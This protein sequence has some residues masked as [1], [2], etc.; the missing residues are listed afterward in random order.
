MSLFDNHSIRHSWFIS[1]NA[2]LL[3]LVS[4]IIFSIVVYYWTGHTIEQKKQLVFETETEKIVKTIEQRLQD[5]ESALH[6]FQG[7]YATTH[8]EQQ[9]AEAF[10]VFISVMDLEKRYPGIKS[11]E[12]C[13][14]VP[15][16]QKDFFEKETD[17]R[18]YPHTTSQNYFPI[19]YLYPFEKNKVGFDIGTDRNNRQILELAIQRDNFV[20]GPPLD[21]Q[22]KLNKTTSKGI[23]FAGSV[24]F[25]QAAP[26]TY[27][28]SETSHIQ[29]QK[30]GLK[31]I[32][33][34]ML[35]IKNIVDTILK[36]KDISKLHVSLFDIG[37]F[38]KR[39][40]NIQPASL[41]TKNL[42][43]SNYTTPNVIASIQ[44]DLVNDASN[45]LV[46]SV[47]IGLREWQVICH[48]P[49]E[50]YSE[51]YN[52]NIIPLLIFSGGITISFFL[53]LVVRLLAKE[54]IVAMQLAG[55]MTNELIENETQLR[56][57][58]NALP[59]LAFRFDL[60]TTL[61]R[62]YFL[63]TTS[64][65]NDKY[66]LKF[67]FKP[68]QIIGQTIDAIFIEN[69]SNI[70]KIYAKN[71][72]TDSSQ[73]TLFELKVKT[74]HAIE[75]I[76]DLHLAYIND[77]NDDIVCIM[78]DM[79][80]RRAEQNRLFQSEQMLRT[81]L[82]AIPQRV[83]WKDTESHFLG[84]NQLF[85][86]D[87]GLSHPDDLIGKT[88]YEMPWAEQAE[89]YRHI[90]RKVLKTN[91]P[92]LNFEEQ[93]TRD[94]GTLV[95]V[96]TNK[97]PLF[98]HSNEVI[99]IIGTYDD[100]TEQKLLHDSLRESETRTRAIID[101][102]ADAIIVINQWELIELFNPAAERIFGY[103]QMEALGKNIALLMP[104]NVAPIHHQF[105]ER[106]LKTGQKNVIN[107]ARELNAK[108]KNGEIFP[109]EISVTAIE[110]V[111]RRLFIGIIRDISLR[112]AS[113]NE[114][115]RLQRNTENILNALG[116]GVIGVN[117][118]DDIMFINPAAKRMLGW[119]EAELI[120]RNRHLLINHSHRDNTEYHFKDSAIFMTLSH[121]STCRISDE[122]FW[123]KNNHYF[124]VE[125]ITTPIIEQETV[126]GAVIVFQDITERKRSIDALIASENKF[127]TLFEQSQDAILILNE[128]TIVDC[129]LAAIKMLNATASSLVL[130]RSVLDFSPEIQPDEGLPSSFIAKNVMK[131]M[132]LMGSLRFEWWHKRLD[133]SIFPVEVSMTMIP[134]NGKQMYHTVWRDLTEHKKAQAEI[135]RHRDHLQELV[136]E[137]TIDLIQAKELA[138]EGNR[139]KSEFLA[140]MSH[141][142][143][144]PMHAIMSFSEFG[145]EDITDYKSN[146][147]VNT[148]TVT[149]EMR[150]LED[151]FRKIYASGK[152]LLSLLND[153]LDLSKLDAGK[154]IFDMHDHH[155]HTIIQ[156]TTSELESL[157]RKHELTLIIEAPTQAPPVVHC[158]ATKIAHVLR[159]LLSNAI[160]FTPAGKLI[161]IA[162]EVYEHYPLRQEITTCLA[163]HVKDQGIGVPEDELKLIFDKFVQSSKT[164]TGSGGTG[165]G[166]AICKQI[167]EAHQGDIFAQNNPDGGACLTFL[168]PI[169]HTIS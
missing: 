95:W 63:P 141:E 44:E 115:K 106:Y 169:K 128:L 146:P 100:I 58:L 18:I 74:T 154:M 151:Y 54:R 1:N 42:I 28:A 40:T 23:L 11:L 113:E 122:I 67:P 118:Q 101:T 145:L 64:S 99:G 112:K 29:V 166:L 56:I 76:Y 55:N 25:R 3:I 105:V 85:A 53:F 82:N 124:P 36:E 152:R 135:L 159:N 20:M 10:Q 131:Q 47:V 116:E 15:E 88:D 4:S 45:V 17:I 71:L 119:P 157:L 165:L 68:E 70:I 104:I 35:D 87:A 27:E 140:N 13:R 83:F 136:Q 137:Q 161:K 125:Y 129:N 37:K 14:F 153:L 108:R 59:D 73:N 26:L 75:R 127:R 117:L 133:G 132:N 111:D 50:V 5:Y 81:I 84:C 98:N 16:Y 8:Q 155:I 138:E 167:I 158:D 41:T 39:T 65:F 134:L 142:L 61:I 19:E 31:G 91:Q 30:K 160:K 139:A 123:D 149:S 130:Q 79:T 148:D 89:F 69:I 103:S 102:A 32:I 24:F 38:E 93:Q 156:N 121:G 90:D 162:Y 143:R 52:D 77:V 97:V 43:Y 96:R 12:F 80:E 150:T 48:F 109:V 21:I 2:G 46:K 66:I 60:K 114:I 62:N 86:Q 126:A 6:A 92:V 78:R 147:N 33:L 144:T 9:A 7:F 34:G 110:L 57:M 107:T 168:L 49:K 94:D 72:S 22:D 120:G 51:K 163:V 164:R